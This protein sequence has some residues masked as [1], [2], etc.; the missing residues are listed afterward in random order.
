MAPLCAPLARK[1]PEPV[2]LNTLLTIFAR[3]PLP[4]GAPAAV[5][6]VGR[7]LPFHRLLRFEYDILRIGP[8]PLL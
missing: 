1:C 6:V 7:L 3:L 2:V 4:S 8:L 5:L